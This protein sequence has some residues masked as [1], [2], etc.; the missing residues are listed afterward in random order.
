MLPQ[1]F[2]K[3]K[4][5]ISEF[6][7]LYTSLESYWNGD[8]AHGNGATFPY[9][10]IISVLLSH[11]YFAENEEKLLKAFTQ[12]ENLDNYHDKTPM[13]HYAFTECGYIISGL[14]MSELYEDENHELLNP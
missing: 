11:M 9:T 8:K 14:Q 13:T 3:I 5:E 4:K 2:E 7:K 6:S 1:T 10:S 12:I